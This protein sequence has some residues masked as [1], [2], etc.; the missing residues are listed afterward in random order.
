MEL[1]SLPP[2]SMETAHAAA[3]REL[4]RDIYEHAVV[5]AIKNADKYSFQSYI[6]MLR[7]YYT[8]LRYVVC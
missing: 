2:I 4:A 7:P 3:E 5:L 6:S 8:G 1:D